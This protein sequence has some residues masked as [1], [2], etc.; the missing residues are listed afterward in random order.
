MS[1]WNNIAGEV[2]RDGVVP[3]RGNAPV[4]PV[5]VRLSVPEGAGGG[6][7]SSRLAHAIQSV[8]RSESDVRQLEFLSFP[9][10]SRDEQVYLVSGSLS[11]LPS[12]PEYVE[13][14]KQLELGD[15]IGGRSDPDEGSLAH[16]AKV[17]RE[18]L[19]ESLPADVDV[20]VVRVDF[21]TL[22]VSSVTTSRFATGANRRVP[23]GDHVPGTFER[24]LNKLRDV[25]HVYQLLIDNRSKNQFEVSV[26]V[27][28]CDIQDRRDTDRKLSAAIRHDTT[29]MPV[30]AFSD[31]GLSS[32]LEI[33]SEELHAGAASVYMGTGDEE[34]DSMRDLARGHSEFQELLQGR[35]GF[36]PVYKSLGW[37]PRFVIESR[38]LTNFLGLPSITHRRTPWGNAPGRWPPL[39][40]PVDP[41][42]SPRGTPS[43]PQ[44]STPTPT[45]SVG[46]QSSS[47][48]DGGASHQWWVKRTA[49]VLRER[50]Y[51]VDVVDQTDG[52]SV[53]DLWSLSPEGEVAAVEVES[54]NGSKPAN[55]LT[56]MIR[57]DRWN[58]DVIIV[59]TAEE[60]TRAAANTLS[61]PFKRITS[62]RT[63]L[64][65]D[66][67]PVQTEDGG[68]Q[69]LPS[70]VQAASWW[71]TPD[72]ELQLEL[73][74]DVVATGPA[75]ESTTTFDYPTP[76][77]RT[78]ESTHVVEAPD[79]TVKH[80]YDSRA[81][82]K[83]DWSFL[84][85][86]LV[87]TRLTYLDQ[88]SFMYGHDETLEEFNPSADWDIGQN[89][90]RY[91]H[92]IEEH[93]DTFTI[94][95][96]GADIEYDELRSHALDWYRPQTQYKDPTPS[97]FGR[98][99]PD[100]IE[101]K[102]N[103]QPVGH[104]T[105]IVDRT[106]RYTTGLQSPDLPDL[107][108][109]PGYPDAWNEI[110]ADDSDDGDNSDDE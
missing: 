68:T 26:R 69:L 25:P 23:P 11:A 14:T 73:D 57:A 63:L 78:E 53:P 60:K 59:G 67:T 109:E 105:Y 64:Y 45:A 6:A 91:E 110:E 2:E 36:D 101:K 75:T 22:G 102:K 50:G 20:D 83:D 87:P 40:E 41:S 34:L 39:V 16:L 85:T 1:T 58:V 13:S 106:W 54:K 17:L 15:S 79:G 19:W 80:R 52:G 97:M 108:H 88:A 47:Q 9:A 3:D 95:R 35:M 43:E 56:N 21:S 65:N 51:Q 38:D 33:A 98:A 18:K 7:L 32:N 42:S 99:L 46:N 62:N 104:D 107:D 8:F 5:A 94:E 82:L 84:H 74:D 72:D 100:H 12:P 28:L 4:R 29:R 90:D 71:L 89:M 92:A 31:L 55:L 27:A 37:Y 86:P 24:L 48:K 30:S 10:A 76:V 96:D 49:T 44:A 77:Y 81:A 70:G 61:K 103:S 66:T 93:L